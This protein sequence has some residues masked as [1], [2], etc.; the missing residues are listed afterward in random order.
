[1]NVLPM[2]LLSKRVACVGVT[3][4]AMIAG[5]SFADSG[6]TKTYDLRVCVGTFANL[7]KQR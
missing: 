3:A 2:W 6:P 4:L 1:M 7:L 5:P